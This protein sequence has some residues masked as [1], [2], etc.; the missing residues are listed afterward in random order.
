MIGLGLPL[1][2]NAPA[3]QPDTQGLKMLCDFTTGFAVLNENIVQISDIFAC[4]R[5]TE[6]RLNDGTVFA[7]NTLRLSTQGLLIEEARNN[8]LLT[9]FAPTNQTVTLAAGTYTLSVGAGGSASLSGAASAS[10]SAGS[11]DTFTLSGSGNVDLAVTGSPIWVQLEDGAFSTSPIATGT[12]SVTRSY[13]RVQPHDLGWFTPDNMTFTIEWEQLQ[14]GSL[15][16]NGVGNVARWSGNAGYSRIRAGS[17]TFAQI[18]NEAG[19]LGMNSGVGGGTVVGIHTMTLTSNAS[20]FKIEWSESL[21]G[22]AGSVTSQNGP[23]AA[24]VSSMNIGG[25]VGGEF[26]NGFIRKISIT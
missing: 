26:I 19:T 2:P 6:G 23:G 14:N 5:T 18:R 8:V 4:T 21:N 17:A 20:E 22:S 9:S 12:T 16:S 13:D 1:W 7:P 10:A 24:H 3:V 11:S 25:N 15:A